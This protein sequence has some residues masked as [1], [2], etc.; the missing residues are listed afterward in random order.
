LRTGN[1]NRIVRNGAVSNRDH[2]GTADAGTETE[3]IVVTTPINEV[4][5]DCAVGQC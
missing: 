3:A 5:S 1:M 2:A 4:V